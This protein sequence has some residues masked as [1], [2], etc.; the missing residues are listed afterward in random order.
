M[1]GGDGS[2]RCKQPVVSLAKLKLAVEDFQCAALCSG[3]SRYLRNW[4]LVPSD[5]AKRRGRP[6]VEHDVRGLGITY[7]GMRAID[8]L[9]DGIDSQVLENFR[10][11]ASAAP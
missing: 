6:E 1:A 5:S 9:L 7:G 2:W 11:R 8:R 10:A 4:R 3:V